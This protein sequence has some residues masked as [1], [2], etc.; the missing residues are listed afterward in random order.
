MKDL[1]PEILSLLHFSARRCLVVAA[2]LA[3]LLV[4]AGAAGQTPSATPLTLLSKDGRRAL[5]LYSSG[6]QEFVALD[7]LAGAFQ[8]AVRDDALGAITV[9][10]KGKTIVLTPDQTLA[11]VSGRLI[12]LPAAPLRL[13]VSERGESK[14]AVPPRWLVP[15]EFISRALAP[16]YD[17]RVDFRKPSH[18]LIIGEL[19]VPRVTVRYD[20]QPAGGRLTVDATPRTPAVVSQDNDR[21]AIRFDADALDL[22]LPGIQAA[23]LVQGV[24]ALDQTTLAVDLGPRFASFRASTQAVDASSRLTIDIVAAQSET[25]PAPAPTPAPSPPAPPELPGAV[26]QSPIRTIAIDAGHGGDDSGVA[27]AAGTKEK[28]L[29]LAVSRRL[30]TALETRLG[31]RVILTRDE[32]R[33][34]PIDERTATANHNKA[35]VFL[36]L[37]ANGSLRPRTGG[38][39]ILYAS[40]DKGTEEAARASSGA[41]RV[42][43]FGGGMRD[44]EL[45]LWDLAQTRHVDRSSVFAR[46]LE[47]QL[48]GRVP[49]ASRPVDR[50][51]LLVLE[52]ANMP[53]VL[54]EM[55]YLTNPDQERHLTGN[56]TQNA[57][58]QAI[59]EAVLR[60]REALG[61]QT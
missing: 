23:G 43:T 20:P 48:R 1:G 4:L 12:S 61:G 39:A 21:L 37:H 45:V 25:Q 41:E 13:A 60:F 56:D 2:A 11:S 26:P 9:S 6:D 51:P 55:G 10:Y 35:D 57:L 47:A 40:F 8:L 42:P 29:T 24:R 17:V 18:L 30:K 38:A 53:A 34:V 32:D 54:I 28:D 33:N 3:P 31:I 16:I 15:V 58:V 50:A 46:I 14:G 19:R 7:D 49:L 36:S 59:V 27:G 52:S 5:P 44:I 22:A